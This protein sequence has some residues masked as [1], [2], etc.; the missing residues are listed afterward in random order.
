MNYTCTI[1]T[2]Y[3]DPTKREEILERCAKIISNALRE[4]AQKAARKEGEE[5][6]NK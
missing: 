6:G 1:H 4:N 2:D 5:N 3:I